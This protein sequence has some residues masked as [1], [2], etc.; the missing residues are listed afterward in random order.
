MTGTV[1]KLIIA[2]LLSPVLPL[3]PLFG[4]SAASKEDKIAKRQ[5]VQ[6]TWDQKIPMRDGIKLSAIV[7][8]PLDQKDPLP[9]ILT[10]TPY[11]AAGTA[12]VG[13]YFAQNGY[14]FVSV[15]LRGR[16]N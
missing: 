2:L 3:A 11:I 5:P 9:V 13:N 7:Y 1:R 14:V 10:M 15:D 6:V 8:R 16:G 12:K 4:Q